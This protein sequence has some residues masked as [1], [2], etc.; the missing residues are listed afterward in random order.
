MRHYIRRSHIIYVRSLVTS[1]CYCSATGHSILTTLPARTP[2]VSQHYLT[3]HRTTSVF[4]TVGQP[5]HRHRHQLDVF[6]TR[7]DQSVKSVTVDR[8]LLSDHSLITATFDAAVI[9]MRPHRTRSS[10]VAVGHRSTTTTSSTNYKNHVWCWTLLQT[11]MN[12]WSATT[13]RLDKFAPRRQMKTT[14][15]PCRRTK[16]TTC[17]LE[18]RYRR[19]PSDLTRS[20][21]RLQFSNQRVLFQKKLTYYLVCRYRLMS[22]QLEGVVVKAP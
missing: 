3:L 6:V 18:K 11:S 21:W 16:A 17:K 20:A 4:M 1:T 15:R 22:R 14:V 12:W 7:R 5:T 8:S 10:G 2:L 9:S 13:P 19:N